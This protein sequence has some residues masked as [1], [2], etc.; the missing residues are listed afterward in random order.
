MG[1]EGTLALLTEATLR[2]IPLPG[3][4]AVTLLG[5]A[6]QENALRVARAALNDGPVACDILD[7]RLLRLASGSSPVVAELIPGAT[8]T[9]LIAE[10]EGDSSAAALGLAADFADYAR[11]SDLGAQ[12]ARTA[13]DTVGIEHLLLVRKALLPGLYS[14]RGP[15]QP[16]AFIEDVAV[17][18][19]VLPE[20]LQ[21]VQAILKR[22]DLISS[23]LI[24]VATG[25]VHMRP[26]LS[27]RTRENAARM[28]QLADE[29]HGV[30]LDLGGTISSRHGVGIA[31]TP[32]VARQAGPLYPVLRELK[33]IFDPRHI[34]NPGKIIAPK[35]GAIGWPLRQVEASRA[36]TAEPPAHQ[37]ASQFPALGP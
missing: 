14:L 32:W 36:E 10:F 9:V 19:D 33:A 6:S 31:R 25:Q 2:T 30:V 34:F 22:Y 18:I 15:V 21:R 24:H 12:F 5:F 37:R 28:W 23:C 17:P 26:F 1:T 7:R 16:L 13:S 27:A 20:Y 8:E 4:R 29:V 35:I 3:G 11:F